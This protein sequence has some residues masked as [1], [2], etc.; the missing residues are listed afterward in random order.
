MRWI[1]ILTLAVL[2][3]SVL[4]YTALGVTRIIRLVLRN[5][6]FATVI[7]VL[8]LLL[9]VA[10]LPQVNPFL[11]PLPPG[12]T[13]QLLPPS[14]TA[15]EPT[16]EAQEDG[17]PSLQE[18]QML[19]PKKREL[20]EDLSPTPPALLSSSQPESCLNGK[21]SEAEM[22]SQIPK[23]GVAAPN[24]P[25]APVPMETFE[26]SNTSGK[27][28]GQ[29]DSSG[30]VRASASPEPAKNEEPTA[31][32]GHVPGNFSA[33]SSSLAPGG[34]G[35][36]EKPIGEQKSTS[37]ESLFSRWQLQAEDWINRGPFY[38]E[39]K[40]TLAWPISLGPY[41]EP[42]E[43]L[44]IGELRRLLPEPW[45]YWLVEEAPKRAS[46]ELHRH[47]FGPSVAGARQRPWD[48]K[49][50]W[51]PPELWKELPR[52]IKEALSRFCREE[53]GSQLVRSL[54]PVWAAEN[55]VHDVYWEAY[56]LE[57][58]SRPVLLDTGKESQQ[59]LELWGT[60]IPFRVHVLLLFDWSARRALERQIRQAIIHKRVEQLG[61]IFLGLTAAMALWYGSLRIASKN[62]GTRQ[63]V[64]HIG[65]I[66][67]WLVIALV[68]YQMFLV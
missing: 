40:K 8:M 41:L 6:S 50:R 9:L 1:F 58:T 52:E 49:I 17:N 3:S 22:G 37:E 33:G 44:S 68:I 45:F 25:G 20:F 47:L 65:L 54:S 32:A 16:N 53:L 55:L 61:G 43:P 42:T 24:G 66:L 36:S 7:A 28:S 26:G 57:G 30:S 14:Q 23:E 15:V 34:E 56:P 18:N 12:Q 5:D 35:P 31:P 62:K 60:S 38:L 2:L 21:S 63:F 39:D 64:P 4:V 29:Q 13:S 46:P 48:R 59:S 10:V 27:T 19:A 67:G 51:I 11:K